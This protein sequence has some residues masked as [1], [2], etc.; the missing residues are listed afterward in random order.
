MLAARHDDDE[1]EKLDIKLRISA[2]QPRYPRRPGVQSRDPISTSSLPAKRCNFLFLSLLSSQ[3]LI[4]LLVKYIEMGKIFS[5]PH[6]PRPNIGNSI[7]IK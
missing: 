4:T 3:I 7:S 2:P 6:S 5:S 1:E